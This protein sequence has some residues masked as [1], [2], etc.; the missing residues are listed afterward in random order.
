MCARLSGRVGAA[1]MSAAC[2]GALVV[3][4]CSSSG[5]GT[6]SRGDASS[7]AAA[8]GTGGASPDDAAAGSGATTGSGGASSGGARATGGAKGNSGGVGTGGAKGS[9]GASG[10]GATA[11]TGGS[12]ASDAGAADEPIGEWTDAPGACPTGLPQVVI[13]TATQLASAARGE[14]AYASDVPATCYLIKNGTY[15]MTGVVFYVLRGGDSD[16]ARRHFVGESRQG[17]VIHGRGNVEDGVSNVTI[18]NLTFDLT[19]YSASGAFNTLN[20]GDGANVTIDHVTFT[21]DCNTGLQGGHI[22]TNHTTNVLVDSCLVEKFGH[23]GGGGHEDHGIYLASGSRITIRNSVVSGNSSRGIQ[24]YTQQGQYG[25]LDQVRVERCRI[26]GNGHADYEDG[27]VINASGT[28][29]IT[30]VT[31]TRSLVYR[32]FYSGIRFVGGAEGSVLVDH[33]TFDSNGAGSTSASRSEINVDAMGGAAGTSMTAN[34]FDVG[35]VLINDCYDGASMGFGIGPG[36]VHG[37]IPSG[38][39]GSC[40]AAQTTGDPAFVD[41]KTG[42]YHPKNPAA[43]AFGAYAP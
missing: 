32:N 27:I 20:L 9:G 5:G 36:F 28:G 17:V 23:C 26:T 18:T 15:A 39:K 40:V 1:A 37:T 7:E 19:G 38:A 21:G 34:L 41:P 43:S 14:G 2:F 33:S 8:T 4:G 16:G 22:E 42:D 6:T 12:A 25:T 35:N 13:T 10:S 31:I 24:M 11:S 29:T 3:T 30:Q